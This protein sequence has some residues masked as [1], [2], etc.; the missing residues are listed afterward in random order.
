MSAS[1]NVLDSTLDLGSI[2]SVLG[3]DWCW[4]FV[5][6]VS[7]FVPDLLRSTGLKE[8]HFPSQFA[9]K[10]FYACC[11]FRGLLALGSGSVLAIDPFAKI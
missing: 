4:F 8:S 10:S 7:L 2:T 11:L 9:R 6:F 1:F 3:S 5:P